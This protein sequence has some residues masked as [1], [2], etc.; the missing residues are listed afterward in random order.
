MVASIA[1]SFRWCE[2]RLSALAAPPID[3]WPVTSGG[4]MRSVR[5]GAAATILVAAVYLSSHVPGV[6]EHVGTT[7]FWDVGVYVLV[8]LGSA[9]VCL[10]RAAAVRTDR[11]AWACIGAGLLCYAA[12]TLLYQAVI[13]HLSEVPYPS[14]SDALWLLLYPASIVGVWLFVRARL[15]GSVISMWLDALTSGLGLISVSAAFVFP[16]LTEGASGPPAALVTNFAYPVLDL[17]LAATVVGGMAA[18]AAWRDRTWLLL[19][20]GFLTFA[21][22]DSWYLLQ[23]AEGAYTPGSL[24]D[25]MYVVAA[26]VIAVSAAQQP[27]AHDVERG[28]ERSFLLPLCFALLALGVLAFGAS[29]DGSIPVLSVVLAVSSLLAAGS[30]TALAVR[31][32]VQ[33]AG[34]RRQALTD[35]LTGL[36]NRRALYELAQAASNLPADDPDATQSAVLIVDLDR[37]KEINDALGHHIGDMVLR[38][39]AER[40]AGRVP[41]GATIARLGGDELA[42]FLPGRTT[43]E[44]TKL[45][46]QL[47]AAMDVPFTVGGL[48]L[49]LSASIGITTIEPGSDVGQTLARA[50]LAMYRAKAARSGW[51]VYDAAK[52]GDAWNRL[53]TIEFL[54]ET[55]ATG[56]LTVDFQPIVHGTTLRPVEVEALVRWNH[57]VHGPTAPDAFLPLA[58]QAGLMPLLTR[59]VLGLALDQARMFRQSGQNLRVAVNLSASDLLDVNLVE[60][61]TEALAERDLPGSALRLEITESLLVEDVVGADALLERLR[62]IGVELAVDDYGTGFSSLSYLHDLP[63]STLKIDRSF[64]SRLM[65]DP[66]TA[67]IVASTIEMAHRLGLTVVAEGVETDEQL[68]WL[69]E[70]GCDYLQGYRISRPVGADKLQ[71]WLGEWSAGEMSDYVRATP[72]QRRP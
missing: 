53:A 70:N 2:L 46:Q 14:V 15:A 32:V 71:A 62:A 40:L 24:V 42:L 48:A 23:I 1:E 8:F 55:L 57:P 64:T 51:E 13:Q 10:V 56:G 69:R 3:P 39:V 20:I 19:V 68:H 17:A 4:L 63:V 9:L 18:L 52:D 25:G 29:G 33:L 65:R 16:R 67:V 5:V 44:A 11:L 60:I 37:F 35:A 38:A 26:T 22:A 50:D 27:A 61:I 49:H 12:G 58:E 21:V 7:T 43:P 66:R 36:P 30:R 41:A 54:R 31:E 6:R 45:A 72:S 28:E 47:L 59:V 34:S